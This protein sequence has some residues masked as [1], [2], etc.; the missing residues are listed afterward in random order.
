MNFAFI[1]QKHIT[2][3]KLIGKQKF[4]DPKDSNVQNMKSE[5]DKDTLNTENL[6]VPSASLQSLDY[7]PESF[8]K[9]PKLKRPEFLSLEK[10]K[11]KGHK[12][13]IHQFEKISKL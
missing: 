3:D 10:E 4:N 6:E 7:S 11:V 1:S 5:V 13:C 9:S 12:I 2:E 8:Q